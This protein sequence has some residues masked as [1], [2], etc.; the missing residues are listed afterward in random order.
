MRA[1]M[2]KYILCVTA[3]ILALGFALASSAE[4]V[5]N[6]GRA[7]YFAFQPNIFDL[8]SLT[9]QPS[10]TLYIG[11]ENSAQGVVKVP[12]LN[13][14]QTFSVEPGSLARISLPVEV[15]DMPW[16]EVVNKGVIVTADSDITVYGLNRNA[17]TTDA[18]LAL[19][20]EAASNVYHAISYYSFASYNAQ[21][22]IVGIYDNTEVT[23]TP[24]Y[25]SRYTGTFRE[26]EPFT[27]TLNSGEV[28]VYRAEREP[29]GQWYGDWDITGSLF[30]STAPIALM[31]GV[32]CA[33]V[34]YNI[35]YCDHLTEQVPPTS[36]W[37][38]HFLTIPLATRL[39]GDVIRVLASEDATSVVINGAEVATL[40]AGQHFETMLSEPAV[41]STSAPA[42]VA[43][44]SV[45]HR[46]D[47]VV[48]DPFMMIVPPAE[49]YLDSYTFVSLG[50]EEGFDNAFVNVIVPTPDIATLI[51][52]GAEVDPAL[53][54]PIGDGNFSGAQ[55]E[56]DSGD[57]QL[58]AAVPVGVFVYGFGSDDSYGYPG[59]MN[60]DLINARGDR[61][62]PNLQLTQFDDRIELLA[63]DSE[64][65]NLNEILDPNEDLNGNGNIDR[66]S[67]DL[68]QNGVLDPDED[69]NADGV[70]D[71]DT[72]IYRIELETGAENLELVLN[73]FIP[74][75]LR[76][77]F[78]V[79]P[80]DP[81]YGARGTLV[82]QDGA[83]N[84]RRQEITFEQKEMAF[85]NVRLV[86]TLSTDNI[87]LDLASF[88][89]APSAIDVQSGKTILEWQFDEVTL[90][91][92]EQLD[93][94]VIVKNASADE[95]RLVTHDLELFY[96]DMGGL[97]VHLS[98]GQRSISVLSSAFAV[99]LSASM[100]E[101]AANQDVELSASLQNLGQLTAQ[102]YYQFVL[103]DAA[104]TP[105]R[106]LSQET[107]SSLA[108]GTEVVLGPLSFNVGD[109]YLGHYQ[110]L[111]QVRDAQGDLLTSD[112]LG[113]NVVAADQPLY[114]AKVTTDKLHY[115]ANESVTVMNR[116]S[117]PASNALLE[118]ATA[119]TQVFAPQGTLL[120]RG[121]K[122]VPNIHVQSHYDF[123]DSV[124]LADVMPGVYRVQL[125][126]LDVAAAVRATSQY[127]FTLL[128]SQ[129]TGAGINAQV[130]VLPAKNLRTE[131]AQLRVSVSNQGN[132][133]LSSVPMTLTLVDAA[134]QTSLTSWPLGVLSLSKGETLNYVVDWVANTQAGQHVVA[135]V[136]GAFSGQQ[137]VLATQTVVI[138][139]KLQST[140][141]TAGNGRVLVL[142]DSARSKGG[143]HSGELGE[144][145][146]E[147]TSPTLLAE[148]D[149]VA[150]EL[151]DASGQRLDVEAM[152]VDYHSIGQNQGQS[153]ADELAVLGV[154][155]GR[156]TLA[157][158]PAQGA[159]VLSCQ[160]VYLR[161]S[162]QPAQGVAASYDSR[163]FNT[164]CSEV[165][166]G[167][168]LSGQFQITR[169]YAADTSEPH[170]PSSA[171]STLLQQ[172]A[173][174][175]MLDDSGW[176]FKVVHSDEAFMRELAEG[177]YS[178]AVLL[179][180]HIKLTKTTQAA[181]A[182]AVADGL[183][184][185]AAGQHDN[186][187]QHLS[188]L[189]G[190][191]VAGK[192]SKADHVS[193]AGAPLLEMPTSVALKFRPKPLRLHLEGATPL[194][195][196]TGNNKIQGV[197]ATEHHYGEGKVI[198]F[199]FDVL[200]QLAAIDAAPQWTLML[201]SSMSAVQPD[202]LPL[203]TGSVVPI[204]LQIDNLGL[205]SAGE[206]ELAPP[207][208]MQIIDAD[209]GVV[210]ADG[211]LFFAYT[212]PTQGSVRE[213]FWVRLPP[214]VGA[215]ALQ[216]A[217]RIHDGN[218]VL[219]DYGDVQMTLNV[220]PLQ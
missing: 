111:V 73:Q 63:G 121:E 159:S 182:D 172:R 83:G 103:V 188:E 126:V 124:S 156:I 50:E 48:S 8:L 21:A 7:F 51:L 109:L 81:A 161:V 203:S 141:T 163:L 100:N 6:K 168:P 45:G 110:V 76:V 189:F 52:D 16:R 78:S 25:T 181:L 117:N 192:L 140:L 59:G 170:G 47:D 177:G 108:A 136:E 125:D 11:A 211:S 56:L 199:A 20:V 26:G 62:L 75:A 46:V 43:Q 135:A 12:G 137:R 86:S 69:V 216:G 94:D 118:D 212:L 24:K 219:V 213:T 162:H 5:S 85:T 31:S 23:V 197:A 151:Y 127:E 102:A 67:E 18:F 132:S 44:Y 82:V 131:R 200:A 204:T 207:A 17:Q 10:L 53:F 196:F 154:T 87:D 149:Q 15:G 193:L 155:P 160:P 33:N 32:K 42:L 66:R 150:A 147:F 57:H 175:A 119:I 74:G 220:I 91:Q 174:D 120:W 27:I 92:L 165:E 130:T 72:G 101:V 2:K 3:L 133:A 206:F 49:Q 122:P 185:V 210:R 71:K 178:A 158:L 41:I 13:F 195:E 116:I 152:A 153:L 4:A 58:R 105:V 128:S 129:D 22:S 55:L 106:A 217:L 157:L 79:H 90:G 205:A 138:E 198:Y 208:G 214:Q 201:A 40:L 184:V 97:P 88:T 173:L 169:S 30:S 14:E 64:D 115:Q 183:G 104:G 95:Q 80:E 194:A 139:E 113:L 1:N 9:I 145:Q 61:F 114:A 29:S 70:I 38:K 190:I 171:P 134:S 167:S 209:A 60:F 84:K 187:N 34:P 148:G 93:Y 123:Y 144:I 77:S 142:T 35:A 143:K 68:N 37:G 180:E 107:L 191:K 54:F 89:T 19:P 164:G 39:N 186:R 98:L 179:S 96:T 176:R 36:T 215:V 166:V 146:V 28:Y 112:A 65:L 99:A 202:D 218:G